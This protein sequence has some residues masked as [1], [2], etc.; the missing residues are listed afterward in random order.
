MMSIIDFI[1][2]LDN[3]STNVPSVGSSQSIDSRIITCVSYILRDICNENA[4]F[5]AT[6]AFDH[7]IGRRPS[8]QIEKYFTERIIKYMRPSTD[9]IIIAL[10]LI[11]KI[12]MMHCMCVTERNVHRLIAVAIVETIKFNDDNGYGNVYYTKV[13][14]MPIEEFNNLEILFLKL[15]DSDVWIHDEII[16]EYKKHLLRIAEKF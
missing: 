9:Y 15:L 6:S 2:K 4:L 14:G 1:E 8:V 16:Q 11:D 13:A 10:A 7:R 12:G 3:I 5:F